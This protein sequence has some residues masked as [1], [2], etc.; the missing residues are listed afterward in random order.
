VVPA[1]RSKVAGTAQ[2]SPTVRRR[3]LAAELRRLREA[4]GKTHE[5]VASELGWHRSKIGRIEGGEGVRLVDA[6]GRTIPID[7]PGAG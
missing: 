4:N 3:R 2:H 7:H 5:D 6:A 1:E